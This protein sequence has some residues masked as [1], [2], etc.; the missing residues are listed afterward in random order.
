LKGEESN[1][2]CARANRE[3]QRTLDSADAKLVRKLDDLERIALGIAERRDDAE[4][5]VVRRLSAA[6]AEPLEPRPA[7]S[8]RGRVEGQLSA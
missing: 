3:C 4:A 5:F 6:G 1:A 2:L 7:L 8:E